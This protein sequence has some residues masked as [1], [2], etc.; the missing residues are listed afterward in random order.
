MKNLIAAAAL[1]LATTA[2]SASAGM[3]DKM[4]G[5]MQCS[6]ACNTAYMQCLGAA[7][8]FTSNPAAAGSQIAANFQEAQLLL[9]MLLAGAESLGGIDLG[10]GFGAKFEELSGE[11]E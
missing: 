11:Q 10:G 5:M 9:D 1:V 2:G 6:A 7:N 8:Q 4:S 3:M